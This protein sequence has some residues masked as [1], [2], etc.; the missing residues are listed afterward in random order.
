MVG[1]MVKIAMKN[2]RTDRNNGGN[3]EGFANLS[4][5]VKVGVF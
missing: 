4:G 5:R 2:G 1:E 3:R